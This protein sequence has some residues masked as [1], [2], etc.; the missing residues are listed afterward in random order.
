[1]IIDEGP[2]LASLLPQRKKPHTFLPGL[3]CDHL[4][5]SGA[6]VQMPSPPALL[7][8]SECQLKLLRAAQQCPS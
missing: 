6:K 2:Q 4:E 3:I 1:M 7:G 5:D 8:A